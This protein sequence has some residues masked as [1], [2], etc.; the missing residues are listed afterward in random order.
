MNTWPPSSVEDYALLKQR[1]ER[2]IKQLAELEPAGGK[3]R[4]LKKRCE[5][6]LKR[7]EAGDEN[8]FLLLRELCE[9]RSAV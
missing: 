1:C 3:Y 8:A 7:I 6:I 4:D 5:G 2:I 9:V